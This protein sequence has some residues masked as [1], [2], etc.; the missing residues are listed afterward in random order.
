MFSNITRHF[1]EAFYGITRHFAMA[2]S[3]ASAVSITLIL[4]GV[5]ML[6]SANITNIT[7]NIEQNVEIFVKLDN[8]A[9]QV[10][11]DYLANEIKN[12]DGVLAVNYSSK[13]DELEKFIASYGQEYAIYRGANNPMH[14]A[15]YVKVEKGDTLEL[16][17]KQ[18]KE[19][20][21]IEDAKFGGVNTVTMVKTMNS[22]NLGAYIAAGIFSLLAIFLIN[23]TIKITIYGRNREIAIMR[24]VGATNNFI[25]TP[26]MIEGIFIGVLGSVLPIAVIVFGYNYL[27][28]IMGGHIMTNLLS[29]APVMP[30]VKDISLYLLA[31]GCAV[32]LIGSF[33]SV[34][35]YLRFRR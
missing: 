11:I 12:M 3:S 26:F 7:R 30:A 27:Y 25:R 21:F 29:L 16:I 19:L 28:Q 35:R 5:V 15:F 6:I 23:N 8:D 17:T 20:Q 4:I 34:S 1:R 18:I 32:G 33:I 10:N 31:I 22:I 24:H 2:F 14:N 13:D 9:Q